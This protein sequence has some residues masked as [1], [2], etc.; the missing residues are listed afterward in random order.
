MDN[1][2]HLSLP[3]T[4]INGSYVT[5]QQD[6]DLEAAHCVQ[7]ITSFERGMRPEDPDFGIAD[8]AFEIQPIDVDDIYEAIA[9]YEPRVETDITTIDQPDGAT[10]VNIRVTMP[11]SEDT[12]EER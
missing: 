9:S 10:V 5:T 11:T 4:I 7:V 12:T 3:L 2:P 8:P 1:L 6:T